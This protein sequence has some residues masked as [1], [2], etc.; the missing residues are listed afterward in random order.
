[1]KRSILFGALAFF[2]IS[3]MSIQNVDAQNPVKKTTEKQAVTTVKSSKD[4]SSDNKTA[5]PQVSAESKEAKA[6]CCKAKEAKECDNKG[7]DCCSAAKDGKK[8]EKKAVGKEA[9][10]VKKPKEK[11][12]QD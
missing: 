6:D 1:M 3:A 8:V 7:K 12:A 11:K 4:A 9:K 5:K 2:A 10:N